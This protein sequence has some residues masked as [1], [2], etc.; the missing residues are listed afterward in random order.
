MRYTF[1]DP[2]NGNLK[3]KR[4]LPDGKWFSRSFRTTD[5][6]VAD[7]KWSQ[8]DVEYNALAQ[9]LRI[10][11]SYT[12]SKNLRRD[13]FWS[14]CARFMVAMK[15]AHGGTL[16]RPGAGEVPIETRH[17]SHPFS[18]VRSNFLAWAEHN[19]PDAVAVFHMGDKTTDQLFHLGLVGSY[20]VVSEL[21]RLQGPA[22]VLVGTPIVPAELPE[23]GPN[24]H[25]LAVLFERWKAETDPA[26]STQDDVKR[27][28]AIFQAAN[29]P[30]D[31]ESPRTVEQIS[32]KHVQKMRDALA[33]GKLGNVTR[34][35]RI[36]GV[37]ILMGQAVREFWI[38][39]NPC[40]GTKF[41]VKDGERVKREE[42]RRDDIQAWMQHPAF[43]RHEFGPYGWSE[44]WIPL[45]AMWHGMRRNEVGLLE[46]TDIQ[47]RDQIWTIDING[48]IGGGKGKK[49]KTAS[50]RRC[51][52]LHPALIRAG[53]LDWIKTLPAGRLF[54]NCPVERDGSIG[55][56][57]KFV[58]EQLDA[59]GISSD[60][61]LHGARHTFRTFARGTEPAIPEKTI[62]DI[63]GH[64]ATNQ[65]GRYGETPLRAMALA[66][67][68][69]DLGAEPKPFNA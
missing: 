4:E 56:I 23:L 2:R 35:K 63:V 68:Q 39:S 64:A 7:Q 36:A 53:A 25:T 61:S 28:M 31:P 14:A 52:P 38:D 62:D 15:S 12:E 9:T 29:P 21:E 11:Q 17:T 41:E 48:K 57:S 66:L 54:Q 24:E 51:I 34:N 47:K 8:A 42:F 58:R 40:V 55:C 16:P 6:K 46:T 20:F 67:A 43:T 44:Y 3:Y 5:Q 33:G 1:R 26:E 22:P 45:L 65:G 60:L 69:I 49:L 13:K 32:R 59:C 50:S 27:A 37:S 10:A 30:S 18:F 19:D